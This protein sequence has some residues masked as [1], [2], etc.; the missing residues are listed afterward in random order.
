MGLVTVLKS[1]KIFSEFTTAQLQAMIHDVAIQEMRGTNR[2]GPTIWRK[3]PLIIHTNI[4]T[5]LCRNIIG[6][7][8]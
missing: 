5:F 7:F 4:F 8:E 1:K 3:M 6:I 2:V